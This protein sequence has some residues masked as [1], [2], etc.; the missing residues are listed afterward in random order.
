MTGWI[1]M[2]K[3]IQV[4]PIQKRYSYHD[5]LDLPALLTCEEA[6]EIAGV[7]ARFVSRLCNEGVVEAT[8]IGTIWRINTEGWLRRCGLYDQ[9]EGIRAMEAEREALAD[10]RRRLERQTSRTEAVDALEN[11]DWS[12]LI[13]F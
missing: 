5:L 7:S 3:S 12:A 11:L 9:V 8:R 6:A 1:Q 10:A 4:I 13:G 2:P